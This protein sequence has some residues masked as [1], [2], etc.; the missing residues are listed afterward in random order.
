MKTDFFISPRIM[1]ARDNHHP[2]AEVDCNA[3]IGPGA[4]GCGNGPEIRR[5]HDREFRLVPSQ[6][7]CRRTQKKLPGEQRVPRLVRNYSNRQPV[8]RVSASE[9]V[10]YKQ[11][12]T[13]QKYGQAFVYGIKRLRR[14]GLVHTSPVD[15]RFSQGVFDDV[16]IFGGAAGE[17][18]GTDNEGSVGGQMSFPPSQ[19]P[20]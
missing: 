14:H 8:F 9:T 16:L 12:M 2:P 19:R 17:L 1:S 6:F 15:C 11:F 7:V 18:T 4:V 5:K 10:L 13:I 20:F 3:G